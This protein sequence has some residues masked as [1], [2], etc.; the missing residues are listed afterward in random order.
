[1]ARPQHKPQPEPQSPQAGLKVVGNGQAE[2]SGAAQ[3]AGKP[4]Q[5]AT[6]EKQ[7]QASAAAAR[8]R[9]HPA[10]VWPD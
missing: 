3:Q 1:M 6:T 2:P 10:R 4:A 9:L 7:A 8:R 5:G